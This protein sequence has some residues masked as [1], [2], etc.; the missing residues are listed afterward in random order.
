MN[1]RREGFTLIELLVVIAIIAILA[2]ILFPVFANARDKARQISDLSNIK[3]IALSITQYTQDYDETYPIGNV[4]VV[5][6]NTL[7][8][9]WLTEISGI[10]G[11]AKLFYGPNDTSAGNSSSYN[12]ITGVMNSFG[13]NGLEGVAAGT[14]T[15]LTRLGIFSDATLPGWAVNNISVL[16]NSNNGGISNSPVCKLSEVTEPSSTILLADLQSSDLAKA[17]SSVIGNSSVTGRTSLIGSVVDNQTSTSNPALNTLTANPATT[18]FSYTNNTSYDV[19]YGTT[20][21][22]GGYW[23][24]PNPKR[25]VSNT[26]PKGPS[27]LVSSPFSSKSMTNFAFA[28]GHAKPM[29]PAATNPDGVTAVNGV[30]D[31]NNM[32]LV[33]R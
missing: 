25:P 32:W 31:A 1:K 23:A 33:A 12:G 13:V 28:D 9:N 30:A 6:S 29:K 5:T 22:V 15:G 10:A 27:G 21:A 19:P 14:A 24:I 7:E 11:S 2:A 16:N 3:Q 20:A 26:Y 17:E 4:S 8:Q 18:V